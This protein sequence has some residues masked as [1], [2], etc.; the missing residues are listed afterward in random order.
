[1]CVCVFLLFHKCHAQY[2]HRYECLFKLPIQVHSLTDFE[3]RYLTLDVSISSV[4]IF[5]FFS[6]SIRIFIYLVCVNMVVT[7]A[8]YLPS[9][10]IVH[11]QKWWRSFSRI[12]K[13]GA[14]IWVERVAFGEN[15]VLIT[16]KYIYDVVL[17]TRSYLFSYIW[18]VED[19]RD[20]K[21]VFLFSLYILC[22]IVK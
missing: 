8:C 5:F 1:M 15:Y 17:P 21:L 19:K 18:I 10:T 6:L 11:W 13:S 2:S 20:F 14:S 4:N 22:S 9:W 7:C 16:W 12:I 3:G